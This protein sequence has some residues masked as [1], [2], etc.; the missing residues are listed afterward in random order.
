KQEANRL[1]ATGAADS[2]RIRAGAD[3]Q[4]TE[5]I[6]QAYADAQSIMGEGDAAAAEIYAKA[7]GTNPQFYEF[8]K[9]LE[10]YRSAFSG[11][12]NTLVRSPKSDFFKFWDNAEGATAGTALN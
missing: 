9:S 8:Y 4:R 3:R 1:R 6:A 12:K 11:D 5:L 10:G 2:E 7:Y